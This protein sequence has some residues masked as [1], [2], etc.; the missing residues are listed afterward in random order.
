MSHILSQAHS[1]VSIKRSTVFSREGRAHGPRLSH[2]CRA[3][4]YSGGLLKEER[5]PEPVTTTGLRRKATSP[6]PS[7]LF[8][9]CSLPPHSW[10]QQSLAVWGLPALFLQPGLPRSGHRGSHETAPLVGPRDPAGSTCP[11]QHQPPSLQPAPPGLTFPKS[12]KGTASPRGPRPQS[13]GLPWSPRPTSLSHLNAHRVSSLLSAK[14]HKN[15]PCPSLF[16][17]PF[18]DAHPLSVFSHL[19]SLSPT[20]ML[21]TPKFWSPAQT[22]PLNS[23]LK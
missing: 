4:V 18:P 19:V 3:R 10:W 20:S 1:S 7:L 14:Y 21:V 11:N 6:P 12:G 23:R 8:S 22:P 5:E 13:W 16:Q 2:S 15:A 17:L 9:Q